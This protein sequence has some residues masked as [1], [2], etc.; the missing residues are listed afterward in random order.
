MPFSFRLLF[1][2][3][4]ICWTFGAPPSAIPNDIFQ[5]FKKAN[6]VRHMKACTE[7]NIAFIPYEQQVIFL[8]F[9]SIGFWICV[10]LC[11]YN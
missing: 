4:F 7:I 8:F 6:V 3:L 5:M 9:F 2:Y 11:V 1:I 10:V